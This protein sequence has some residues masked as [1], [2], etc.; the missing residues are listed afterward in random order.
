M[1]DVLRARFSGRAAR[2][3]DLLQDY[4]HLD[5]QGANRLLVTVAELRGGSDESPIDLD[6]VRKVAAMVLF[7]DEEPAAALTEDWRYLFS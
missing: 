2:F 5:D 4:G 6:A 7:S 3:V 1:S